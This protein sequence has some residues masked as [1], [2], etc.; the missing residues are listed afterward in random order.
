METSDYRNS[1]LSEGKGEAYHRAFIDKP[2]RRMVWQF[3]KAI[4]DKILNNFY[5]G[6]TIRHLDFACGTGRILHYLA[7]R[8]KESVGVDLSP[9]MLKVARAHNK[10][11]KIIEADLTKE[12]VFG[13]KT[14]NLITAFRFFP[15]AQPELRAQA[16]QKIN[17]HLAT[18]GYIVFNNHIHSESL[19]YRLSK[20]LG[21]AKIKGMGSVEVNALIKENDLEI[22]KIYHLCVMPASERHT[23]MPRFLLQ[24]L[25]KLM[26]HIPIFYKLAENH[27]YVC[28]RKNDDA[29]LTK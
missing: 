15:N 12:D 13:E 29:I 23:F 11:S 4:L 5:D 6:A 10:K 1:H 2:Y 8:T 19:K 22:I 18:N 3:E 27:I 16:M 17:K 14:F 24:P 25:E 9:S 26:T 28:K 20:V 7:D 21:R